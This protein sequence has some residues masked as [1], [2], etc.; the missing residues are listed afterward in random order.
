MP[1][2]VRF[3]SYVLILIVSVYCFYLSIDASYETYD[4]PVF[5]T[6][7]HVGLLWI[8]FDLFV[9]PWLG[10]NYLNNAKKG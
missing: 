10:A 3:P 2:F 1:N 9:R 6:F 7:A 4:K 8:V 5:E